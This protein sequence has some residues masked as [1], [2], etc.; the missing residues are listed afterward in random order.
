MLHQ[1]KKPGANR[2]NIELR[3][4]SV[5][6]KCSFLEKVQLASLRKFVFIKIYKL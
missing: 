3:C 6:G 2:V 4:G 1:L 5:A